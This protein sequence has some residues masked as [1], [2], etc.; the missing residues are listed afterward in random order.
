LTSLYA[1]HGAEPLSALEAADVIRALA[2]TQGY[3][4]REVLTAEP[5]F[6]WSSLLAAS[7][8]LSLFATQRLVELRIPSGKPGRDGGP[9]IEAYCMR[10]PEDTVTLITLPEID[11]QGQKAKWFMA[12]QEHATMIEAKP[13]DRA[14]LPAWLS[15]RL[16]RQQQSASPEALEV[17][18]DRVEGNLLAAKQEIDKLALL[19]PPG[20]ISQDAIEHGVADVARFD[21]AAILDAIAAGDIARVQRVLDGLKA[22]GEPLPY[23]LWLVA[24]EA[25]TLARMVNATEAGRYPHPGKARALEKLAKRHSPRSVL[26]LMGKAAEV[27][28]LVKGIGT[29]DPWEALA[30]LGCAMAGK[31]LMRSGSELR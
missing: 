15:K 2:K 10:L 14:Q 30:D 9:A 5:G 8:A 3:V 4:E 27:D 28:R 1:I 22:E 11:W 16:T 26:R 31:P 29:R 18:A 17:L 20:E 24:N 19:C 25:R 7:S 6:D 21:A 13:I 23:L 12:L